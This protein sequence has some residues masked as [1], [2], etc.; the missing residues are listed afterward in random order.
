M[1]NSRAITKFIRLFI[2]VSLLFLIISCDS[3]NPNPF[4]ENPSLD[5]LALSHSYTRQFGTTRYD[6]PTSA[7]TDPAGNIYITVDSRPYSGSGINDAYLYKYAANGNFLQ[8]TSPLVCCD[9]DY[10]HM[11]GVSKRGNGPVYVTGFYNQ[12][13]EYMYIAKTIA[14]G[15][16]RLI[17]KFSEFPDANGNPTHLRSHAIIASS[18]FDVYLLFSRI[19]YPYQTERVYLMQYNLTFHTVSWETYIGSMAYFDDDPSMTKDPQGNIYTAISIA[20]GSGQRNNLISKHNNSGNILWSKITHPYGF[21]GFSNSMPSVN[22][23]ANDA[24]GNIY[25]TGTINNVNCGMQVHQDAYIRKYDTDGTVMWTK[26]F[27]TN[28]IDVANSLSID[29]SGNLYIAGHTLGSMQSNVA[30]KGEYD[31]FVRKYDAN[32]NELQTRQFGTPKIDTVYNL[33]TDTNGVYVMGGTWGTLMSP[34]IGSFDAYI[35]KYI[36]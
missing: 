14:D 4:D 11:T 28:T 2:L 12:D 21:C 30:N 36:P 15:S 20:G 26:Q 24:N 34:R 19:S 3:S 6:E 23:I 13:K 5:S 29:A 25:I 18:P 33:T 8:K 7:I 10:H 1:L 31:A 32:G 17:Q 22:D 27:G 16:L 35:R 9:F